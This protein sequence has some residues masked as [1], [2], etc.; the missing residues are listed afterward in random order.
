MMTLD[1]LI[2]ALQRKRQELGQGDGK[3]LARQSDGQAHVREIT[4]IDEE[5]IGYAVLFFSASLRAL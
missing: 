2:T 5:S 4:G 3:V 1:E